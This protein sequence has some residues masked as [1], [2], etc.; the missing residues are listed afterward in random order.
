MKLT[1]LIIL[2]CLDRARARGDSD[3]IS[4]KKWMAIEDT[5]DII[6]GSTDKMYNELISESNATTA[7][8]IDDDESTTLPYSTILSTVSSTS[9]K[10]EME[11]L[12]KIV[13][14]LSEPSLPTSAGS[15]KLSKSNTDQVELKDNTKSGQ[16]DITRVM[17]AER[18][19]I[20]TQQK[21]NHSSRP[22]MPS[23]QK[24]SFE[25]TRGKN[26]CAYVHTRLTPTVAVDNVET[27][28]SVRGNPCAW[29]NGGC[30]V[31]NRIISQPVYRMRH[32][33]VTSLEWKCCPGY[34]G[35]KCQVTARPV[36]M[37]AESNLADNA[38]DSGDKKATY[39]PALHQKLAD[40]IYNQDI[41]LM[42]LQRKVENYSSSMTEV[43]KT[44]SS[45]EGKINNDYKE[46][47]V[48]SLL[49]DLKSK[50]I[51]E[52]IK[53]V[54][55]D[56]FKTYQM[57]TQETI[58]QLF[59]S[60]SGMSVEL[61]RTKQIVKELN[62][63]IRTTG[64]SCI[65]EE[66]NKPTMEDILELKNRV[67]HLKNTA[68]VC[69][70]SFKDMEKKHSALEKE[71]EHEKS[72]NII[73]FDSL[74]NTLSK[75]K[76]IHGELLSDNNA[77]GQLPS[78]LVNHAG[79]N[80]TEYLLSLQDRVKKQNIM[81][82]QLYDDINVQDNKINN[83]TITLEQQKQSIE[84]ACEDKYTSCKDDFQKKLKGTEENVLVLNK[85]VSDVVIPLDD[86]I[87]KMNEQIN[88]LCY[89]MEILQPLIEKGAPFSMTAEYEHQS[90]V[91]EFK[92]QL[93]NLTDVINYLSTRVQ[94]LTEEQSALKN[95]ARSQEQAF[96]RRINECLT[97]VEDGLNNTM[98]ILNNAVD[99]IHD[100][101]VQKSDIPNI[102][103]MLQTHNATAEKVESI[104][105]S[106]P[107]L[108]QINETLQR[109]VTKDGHDLDE[110]GIVS[111]P[112]KDEINSNV[113]TSFANLSE[114]V[115]TLI[116]RSDQC[117]ENIIQMETKLQF[118]GIEIK[119]CLSRLQNIESQVNTI[120]ANPTSSSKSKPDEGPA[121]G[122]QDLYTRIKAL[123]FKTILLSTSM[124]RLNKTASE[125]KGLCQ[126]VF[127][128]IRKVNESVPKLIKA[129]QPNITSLQ[130]GF[131]E[132]M[133]SLIEAKMQAIMS[134]LSNYVDN[135][136]SDVTNNIAKLQK[137]MKVLMKKPVPPKK[138]NANSTVSL[139]GRSQRNS[140]IADEGDEPSSCSSSPCYNG[141]TCIN[142]RKTFVC[143][144]RHPFGG[145][146]C[147][148][149][150][151]DEN[152]QSPDFTKG[153]YRYAP[154]VAFYVSHTYGMT[155]PGPIKF[156]HLYVNYGSSYAP[157]TGKFNV[158]YLGVYVFKYTIE[159]FS[160]RV[161]GY[162]VVDGVDKIAFQSE[163]MNSNMYS[164]RVVTGDALLELNYGQEVWLR[165]AT[166]SIPAQYPPVTT[167]SGYLLYRT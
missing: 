163:N 56:Q 149:K 6:S 35:E 134:N 114:K 153:S 36:Q 61:E 24:P 41:K 151:S 145:A 128:T 50:S 47:E 158:P 147:S 23:K 57:E 69:T 88:D 161:S 3:D 115:D 16:N 78:I 83:L 32:K 14:A 2:L 40:Q 132:L 102:G 28:V 67:E 31:R 53:D 142:D 90:D 94:E 81:M 129:T 72:R 19:M 48:Q 135:S 116:F 82:L 131:E 106:L 65:T 21:E 123:E 51:T 8:E 30:S 124:P 37:Q 20:V 96:E 105:L 164:D 119:S 1:L 42:L 150:M 68:F 133:T 9:K 127:I 33:I 10:E 45:L 64:H 85:T 29:N 44:L 62:E 121:K 108:H 13:K 66:E 167:F 73:Y 152:A 137:Q 138:T 140:D 120:L 160:P 143:A 141:G 144:C 18:K 70:T 117:Q 146:N 25:T 162:L 87:D 74:N 52:L 71:L 98:D 77:K 17:P 104:L 4:E 12:E 60:M 95:D 43:H 27:Y 15:T 101:F 63:T 99:S 38:V 100:D 34:S 26:W 93:K 159:S 11:M 75:M 59:K 165:L 55:K 109:L 110:T 89:D 139:I 112:P 76:E 80:I 49:K 148:L 157:G 113:S 154:M 166:G 97:T 22:N 91:G 122:V 125:A 5:E 118:S 46:K 130:K 7:S 84:R 126:T 107:L 79:D 58:A 156:N 111:N 103:H 136:M 39:D 86:K 155:A 92:R 54:V